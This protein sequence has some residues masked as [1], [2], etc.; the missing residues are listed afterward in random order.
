MG[1]EKE[2]LLLIA[3]KVELCRVFGFNQEDINGSDSLRDDLGLDSLDFMDLAMK[4]EDSFGVWLER[5]KNDSIKTVQDVVNVIKL[6]FEDNK[7]E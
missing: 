6:K 3:V 2:D 1:D 4:I 7:H 5:D